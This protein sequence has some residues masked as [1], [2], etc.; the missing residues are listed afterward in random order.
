LAYPLL[1]NR[2]GSAIVVAVLS[3]GCYTDPV[4]MRPNVRIDTPA[5]SVLRGQALT[6]SATTS[7]PD[8]D[9]VTLWWTKTPGAC[10]PGFAAPTQWPDARQFKMGPTLDVAAGDTSSPWCIWVKAT[11]PPGAATVDALA[12]DA[13]DRPPAAVL[14]L[15]SP[16]YAASFP[17]HTMFVLSADKS[18]DPDPG[19][20]L[21]FKWKASPSMTA[22]LLPCPGEASEAVKCFTADVAGDYQIEVEVFDTNH[23]K[24]SFVTQ[25]LRVLPGQLPVADIELVTPEGRPPYPLGGLFRVSGAHSTGDNG[26]TLPAFDWSDFRP[27]PGSKAAIG[28]CDDAPS[29]DVQCFTADVPG[30]YRV[31]LTVS[32]DAGRSA[33][34][35]ATYEVAPDQPPCIDATTPKEPMTSMTKFS[36]DSASDDLDQGMLHLRWLQ[37]DPNGTSFA[38]AL[39]DFPLF[40]LPTGEFTF[41]DLVR[42]RLEVLD[43]D[44]KRADDAF[45][46]CGNA[47]TCTAVSLIHPAPCFQRVTWTVH[48]LP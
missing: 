45:R 15:R 32:N 10:P 16:P 31:G 6:F 14:E 1:R 35:S 11:D 2:L 25:P 13:L 26:F 9:A 8:N 29:P 22:S 27:A 43:R 46:A 4:N 44:T 39:T 33:P 38:L 34:V 42:V 12:L 18:T 5:T 23:T 7:D 30:P 37:S 48:I 17:L 19:D 28:A 36:L 21:G 24:S 3:V 41:G 20:V 40:T 47:D